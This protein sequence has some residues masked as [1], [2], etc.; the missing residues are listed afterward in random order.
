[1]YK[2]KKDLLS[3]K[4]YVSLEKKEA[5]KYKKLHNQYVCTRDT[6]INI[7]FRIVIRFP[8]KVNWIQIETLFVTYQRRL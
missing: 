3:R 7:N 6:L 1:M 4:K 8:I 5:D 2:S